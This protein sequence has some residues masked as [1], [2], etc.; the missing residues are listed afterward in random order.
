MCVD[1]NVHVIFDES[2]NM[3]EKG[4][5]DEDYDIGI[6]EKKTSG[7]SEQYLEGVSDTQTSEV[8]PTNA[9]PLGHSS[10]KQSLGLQIEPANIKEALKDLDWIMGM[11]EELNQFERSKVWHL[12]QRPKSRTVIG[13]RWVFR[14]KLDEQGN[15]SRNKARLVVQRYNHEQGIDY[16]EIFAPIARMEVIRMLISFAIYMGFTLYQMDVKS[17]FSNGYLKKKVFVKQF[18][19]FESE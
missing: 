13:T 19:G 6:T 8:A 7:E 3:A 15:I 14:N 18:P 4:L 11:Q 9:G 1:E 17:A 10:A 5:Q 2:N 16:D 12:V